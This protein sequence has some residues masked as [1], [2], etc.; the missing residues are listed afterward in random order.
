MKYLKL[1]F[2]LLFVFSLSCYGQDSVYVT[3]TGEKY[4]VETCTHLRYS[5]I[6]KTLEEAI[7]LGY[8]ACSVCKPSPRTNST[9][10]SAL[11]PTKEKKVTTPAT[12]PRSTY[13]VQCS[14]KTQSGRRCKRKT[15]N[16]SGRCYQH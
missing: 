12:K 16:A 14:G 3:K 15:K 7:G 11:T 5:S 10:T 8:S 6:K 1:V 2:L 9:N 13:A 4:H